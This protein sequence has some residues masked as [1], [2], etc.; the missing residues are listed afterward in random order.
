MLRI[1]DPLP[2]RVEVEHVPGDATDYPALVAAMAG[3]DAV[4]HAAMA[5]G[6]GPETE[7][8]GPAFGVNVKSVYL[9]LRA[10]HETGVPH[11][12]YLSS[13]SVYRDP[14][15][16]RLD[17]STPPDAG[18]L[19]GLTKRLGEQVCAAATDEYGL[20][21]NVLRLAWPTSDEAWPAWVKWQPPVQLSTDD[22]TPIPATAATDLVRA[23]VAALEFRDGFQIFQVSGDRSGRLW[24]LD[25]ARTLLGWSPTFGVAGHLDAEGVGGVHAEHG[26]TDVGGDRAPGR[27]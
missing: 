10:A 22:G 9:T 11:A 21:V 24:S 14:T 15:S 26:G 25:K 17:E 23:I 3:V 1:F 7:L 6:E 16:R 19:Y 2:P 4:L 8:A 27:Q 18:D 13:L 5:P 12:V 20:S